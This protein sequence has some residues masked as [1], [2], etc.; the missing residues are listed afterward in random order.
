V[1][2][3]VILGAGFGGITAALELKRLLGDAHR[4]TLVDRKPAFMMGLR[5]IWLVAGTSTRAE[6][7]RPIAALAARGIDIRAATVTAIEP[8]T[9]R[10]DVGDLPF[11]FLVVALGA[12]PRTDLVPGF[13]PAAFNLYSVDDAER[14][15]ARLRSF[16]RG[17]L[18]I[19]I[20]GLP[21]KCPPAPYECAMV[22]DDVFRER[23]MRGAVD[24]HVTTPTPISL[25][26][27]GKARCDQF[28]LLLKDR[29]IAFHAGAKVVALDGSHVRTEKETLAADVL[30]V[31]PP[32]RPPA[33]VAPLCDGDWIRIDPRTTCTRVDRIYAVGD[34]TEIPLENKLTLPK[35]GIFAE[36]QG[37][38]AAANIAAAI[39]GSATA[40]F[41]GVG[42][43]FAEVGRG[44][45]LMVQGRFL[46]PGGPQVELK[47]P[48]GENLEQKR[49]F[50]RS[51][52]RA[53]FG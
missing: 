17:R 19:T 11:D 9:V 15:G 24:L 23:E 37:R 32:H 44:Q 27:L 45:A 48:S 31:V 47:V 42:M 20:A 26:V 46:E 51:R 33:P 21:Y 2:S 50:E 8:R 25:P 5:T 39:T 12:E 4:V 14:L 35:A 52:L 10:T 22:L 16:D 3:I 30:I 6:G 53:W 38:V 36:A 40:E 7:E 34:C 18:V 49:E 29:S 1:A 43:C 28:E 41:D 13:S